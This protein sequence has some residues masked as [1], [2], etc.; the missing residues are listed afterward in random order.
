MGAARAATSR[1]H[2]KPPA[3]PA[4]IPATTMTAIGNTTIR[5][6][7][8]EHAS[9][10]EPNASCACPNTSMGKSSPKFVLTDF[11]E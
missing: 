3:T 7:R 4:A 9:F 6:R 2:V 11:E 8:S 1:R 5:V 10:I